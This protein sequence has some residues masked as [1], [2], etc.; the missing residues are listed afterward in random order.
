MVW[1]SDASPVGGSI[2]YLAETLRQ[3]LPASRALVAID[4]TDGSGKSTR[5]DQLARH[6]GPRP[7]VVVHADDFLNPSAVRHARGRP[8]QT[9]SGS[10]PTTT[11]RSAGTC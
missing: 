5:A 8:H 2:E 7:V 9:A 4:G 1:T 11:Q 6:L 3:R 10:T